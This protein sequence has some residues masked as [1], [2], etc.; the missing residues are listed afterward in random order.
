M[1][2]IEKTIQD[3][4]QYST[5]D[6]TLTFITSIHTTYT[7]QFIRPNTDAPAYSAVAS[8]QLGLS[9][10]YRKLAARSEIHSVGLS[11][12]ARDPI[13]Y[14]T[15]NGGQMDQVWLDI[16]ELN[17]QR[18]LS[19]VPGGHAAFA[20]AVGGGTSTARVATLR[21]WTVQLGPGVDYNHSTSLLLRDVH[22]GKSLLEIKGAC[23]DPVAWSR[24]GRAIAA[25]EP[26]RHR[27]GV[28]D[29][30]TGALL[31][32]V[33]SHIDKVAFAAFTPD[34]HL[35]TA[36][37]DG[38]LRLTN[39]ATSRTIARLE[40]EGLGAGNPRALVVAADGGTVV[41]VWGASVHVWMPRASHVTSYTLASVRRAE[42]VP[43][44]L[45]PDGKYMLCW[46][47]DGFDIMDVLSGATVAE[48]P[49]G[50]LVTAAAFSAD[51]GAVLLGRMDGF[52]E[53]W[54]MAK[55]A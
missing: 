12:D 35:V 22:T 16:F 30:R 43:L 19:K 55:K 48:R 10:R 41:S 3:I 21:D 2:M 23:G 26:R 31:G 4:K 25:A 7:N 45:S 52:L 5:L 33:V 17:S 14:A 49:G 24:D 29:T 18:G 15:F 46:T 37:R 27:I 51:A 34:M 9:L 6:A 54:D 32:R 38:T 36:S 1:D 47:E 20:P 8:E 44:A 13:A 28:W 39:P 50:A 40:I 53:V 11:A 42:G